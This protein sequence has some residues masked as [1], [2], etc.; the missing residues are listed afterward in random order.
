MALE[1][2]QQ[3]LLSLKEYIGSYVVNFVGGEPFL[4]RYFSRPD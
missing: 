2:W 1:D 4:Y 3:A